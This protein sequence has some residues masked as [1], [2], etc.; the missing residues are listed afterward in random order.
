MYF[1]FGK[2]SKSKIKLK[3]KLVNDNS[4]LAHQ[5]AQFRNIKNQKNRSGKAE[6]N[7][8]QPYPVVLQKKHTS[9]QYNQ[10]DSQGLQHGISDWGGFGRSRK[11]TIKDNAET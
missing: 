7:E 2:M 11:Y 1:I 4:F 5:Q 9:T 6:Q 3:Q 8:G 10:K